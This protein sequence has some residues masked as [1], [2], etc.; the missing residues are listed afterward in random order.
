ME[1][2]LQKRGFI[3]MPFLKDLDWL[4]HEIIS[5]SFDQG[6]AAKRGDDV[7]SPGTVLEQILRDIDSADVIL[8]VCT[9]MNANVFFELGYAWREHTPILIADKA[10]SLPF[11]IKHLRTVLYDGD[12][13]ETSRST[14]RWRLSQ[15][16]EASLK[17]ARIPRGKRLSA[18]PVQKEAARLTARL[19]ERG[20]NSHELLLANEGTVTLSKVNLVVPKEASSF[21]V[22]TDELPID[23]M[24]PGDKVPLLASITMGGGKRIFDVTM[25]GYAPGG[26]LL[27]F[28]SKI[29]L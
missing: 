3:I 21:S 12:T 13:A 4:R 11:N 2:D 26:E 1:D 15:A 6:V 14:L 28:K 18:P 20:R 25:Q 19:R 23:E 27:E 22:H 24:R 29:G 5:A 8:V 9:G 16:I 7:F 10:E 17:E